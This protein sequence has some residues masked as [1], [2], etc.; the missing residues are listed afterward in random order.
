[1]WAFSSNRRLSRFDRKTTL[2]PIMAGASFRCAESP[3]CVTADSASVSGVGVAVFL[4]GVGVGEALGDGLGEAK[5][6]GEGIG[7]GVGDAVGV[8]RRSRCG[9]W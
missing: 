5:G 4:R 6:V 9:C 2:I 7:V 3:K 8:A 1:M